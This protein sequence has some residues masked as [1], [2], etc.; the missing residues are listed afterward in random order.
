[1]IEAYNEKGTLFREQGKFEDAIDCYQESH[2]ISKKSNDLI[3]ATDNLQ[4]MGV[5]YYLQGDLDQAQLVS[6]QAQ[7][8]AEQKK[9]PHLA[10]R[11]RRTLANILFHQEKYKES[12]ETAL[13]SCI[14]ILEIDQYSL[15]NSPAM[16]ELLIE[17]WLTWLT[18]DLLEE[19]QDISLRK[20][21]CQYLL[22]YWRE[23]KANDRALVD[24]YPGFI[25]TLEELLS[26]SRV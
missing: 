24:H 22:N 21:Q 19:I 7:H 14:N 18:E 13:L 1:M 15:N 9:S 2:K 25:I 6:I 11:A 10:G 17:E 4:D 26:E 5:A 20:G 23:S 3:W 12:I 8:L 16:R